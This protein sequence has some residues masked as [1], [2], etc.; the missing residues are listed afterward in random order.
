[1]FKKGEE[2]EYEIPLD[3]YPLPYYRGRKARERGK[4]KIAPATT[5]AISRAWWLAGWIDKD[6]E[7]MGYAA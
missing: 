6:I 1:M 7:E 2:P 4:P 5:H 3:A